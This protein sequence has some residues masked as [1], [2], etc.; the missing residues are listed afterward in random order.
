MR[1]KKAV[2][3]MTPAR[4]R[5]GLRVFLREAPHRLRDVIPDLLD[6]L[7]PKPDRLPPA[8]LRRSVGLTSARQEFL[9]AGIAAAHSVEGA[10]DSARREG[11]GAY[12]RWLD[13]GCGTGRVTRHLLG[14]DRGVWGVDVDV[15]AIRWARK[16]LRSAQ[17][18][19]VPPAG[20][21]PFADQSFD[22][23]VSISVF[24]HFDEPLQFTWIEELRRVLRPGGLFIVSTHPPVLTFTRPDLTREEHSTLYGQGFLFA[25]GSGP[26]NEGST[27][28]SRNYLSEKWGQYFELRTYAPHGL[29]GYQDLVVWENPGDRT[30][31]NTRPTEPGV[32]STA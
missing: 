16:H 1:L 31:G 7:K 28:H 23:V 25:P 19:A 4:L 14:R 3:A 13:F 10:F 15:P 2:R 22:V 20:P 27:F 32:P 29:A 17:F 9:R 8:A 6:R 24:T 11:G 5:R 12:D 26:F 18:I 30:P 21:V